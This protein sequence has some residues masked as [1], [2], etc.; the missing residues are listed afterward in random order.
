[1]TDLDTITKLSKDEKTLRR[2]L[3]LRHGCSHSSLYGDDDEMQ[4]GDCGI[5]FKR[6]EPG[7]IEEV[8]RRRGV[9]R[10]DAHEHALAEPIK[11]VTMGA[12][13]VLMCGC[14]V[15]CRGGHR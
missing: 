4:C 13:D 6:M 8:L 2:M 3:W 15:T 14:F 10:L 9:E 1:M 5:D 11:P 12:L 7:L